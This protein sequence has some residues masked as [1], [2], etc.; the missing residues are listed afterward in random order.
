MPGYYLSGSLTP[1]CAKGHANLQVMDQC[2][3]QHDE[4]VLITAH[5][6]LITLAQ[7]NST[8]FAILGLA[9]K[10]RHLCKGSRRKYLLSQLF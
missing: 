6:T 1:G 9:H 7:T 10:H 2:P 8:G 5:P 4:R 3:S